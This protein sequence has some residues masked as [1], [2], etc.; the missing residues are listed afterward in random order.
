[1][2]SL[3][4]PAGGLPPARCVDI[5]YPVSGQQLPAD[6][7]QAVWDALSKDAP[8]LATEDTA[9]IVE[10]RTCVPNLG[11][12]LLPRRARLILRVPRHRAPDG[13]ALRGVVLD[14]AGNRLQLGTG[15]TR[16][17]EPFPTLHAA[18]VNLSIVDELAFSD[19]LQAQLRALGLKPTSI[20]GR[21]RQMRVADRLVTGFPV[22]VHGCRPE[23]SL[24]LQSMGVGEGRGPG[25]GVFIPHKKIDGLDD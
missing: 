6:H 16:E 23:D 9:G 1:M 12:A 24:H 7:R 17:L 21:R 18:M 11:V 22:V 8:W 14:V 20:L 19:R 2:T 3:R 13:L 4:H 5:V 25:C 15:F 10:L